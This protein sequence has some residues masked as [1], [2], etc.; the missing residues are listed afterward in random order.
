M[1][2]DGWDNPETLLEAYLDGLIAAADRPE[3]ERRLREHYDLARIHEEQQRIDAS[4]ARRF[5]P[6]AGERS[7]AI[8]AAAQSAAP[9]GAETPAPVGHRQPRRLMPYAIAAAIGLGV[10][11]GARIYLQVQGGSS[12]VPREIEPVRLVSF[13]EAYDLAVEGGWKPDVVCENDQQFA[14]ITWARTG[15]ALLTPPDM[16]PTLAVVG[17][18]KLKTLSRTSLMLLAQVEGQRVAVFF[19]RKEHDRPQAPPAEAGGMKLFRREFGEA[20][21]YELTPLEQPRML[22]QFYDP[23][24]PVEWYLEGS[25]QIW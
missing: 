5:A 6:P 21:L 16:P 12:I 17:W 13:E 2:Q 1:M 14:G 22:S 23:Q 15:Q 18:T 24:R 8:I 19:D 11:V 9:A 10:V 7:D 4:L 25:Q 3:A 20:V